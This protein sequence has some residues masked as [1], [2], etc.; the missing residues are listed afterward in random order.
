MQQ[1]NIQLYHYQPQ[2]PA[3]TP[4]PNISIN[5]VT[6]KLPKFWS[7]DPTTWFAQAEAAFRPSNVT[8]S[9]TKYDHVSMKLPCDVV[10]TVRDL[11]KLCQNTLA[12]GIRPPGPPPP[13]S[14]AAPQI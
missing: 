13:S 10:M 8:V 9:Y 3:P 5:A 1:L 12:A 11:V 2:Q 6:V 4:Q 14:T 7:A